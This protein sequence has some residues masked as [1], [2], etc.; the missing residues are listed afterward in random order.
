MGCAGFGYAMSV[1]QDMIRAG[2][3]T[4]VLVIGAEEISMSLDMTDKGQ[5][6]HLR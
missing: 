5:C 6:V 4:R 2:S 3:A 1:A